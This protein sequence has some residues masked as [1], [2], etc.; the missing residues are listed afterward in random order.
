MWVHLGLGNEDPTSPA[1]WL[2]KKKKTEKCHFTEEETVSFRGELGPT[3][4]ACWT[5]GLDAV[6]LDVSMGPQVPS[7]SAS[8][9]SSA[10]RRLT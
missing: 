8:P 7:T 5:D 10:S 1:V 9:L 4:P 3:K 6:G 2:K